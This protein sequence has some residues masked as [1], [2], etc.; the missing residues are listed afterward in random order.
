[1]AHGEHDR[2]AARIDAVVPRDFAVLG[3][4]RGTFQS[5][6]R[7]A[8]SRARCPIDGQSKMRASSAHRNSRKD[9]IFARIDRRSRRLDLAPICPTLARNS[10]Y[11]SVLTRD[12]LGISTS[13]CIERGARQPERRQISSNSKFNASTLD[14]TMQMRCT[15]DEGVV[16]TARFARR[17]RDAC[18]VR[19]ER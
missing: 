3:C 13:A 9:V 6:R 7:D 4:T 11:V 1:M 19:R 2:A 15:A 18:S 8:T 17:I 12:H 14:L 10:A 5:M 16:E